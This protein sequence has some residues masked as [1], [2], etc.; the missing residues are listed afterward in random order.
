MKFLWN[1]HYKLTVLTLILFP[2]FHAL[3]GSFHIVLHRTRTI[4]FT[5]T[6]RS[7]ARSMWLVPSVQSLAKNITLAAIPVWRQLIIKAFCDPTIGPLGSVPTHN[8][9]LCRREVS[10]WLSRTKTH[11]LHAHMRSATM[12]MFHDSKIA[13]ATFSSLFGD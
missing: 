10:F 6:W 9:A 3:S 4:S 11:R 13:S 12:L 8:P 2:K 5:A 7:M 1:Q